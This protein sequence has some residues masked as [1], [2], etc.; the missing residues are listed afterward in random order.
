M[1]LLGFL[2]ARAGA[3]LSMA[4]ALALALSQLESVREPEPDATATAAF[5]VGEKADGQSVS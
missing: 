5:R 1:T 2:T 3:L 4:F